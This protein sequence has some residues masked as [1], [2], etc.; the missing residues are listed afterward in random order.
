MVSQLINKHGNPA[1]NQ[2]IIIRK[3]ATYFQ[4]YNS[5]VCKWDGINLVLSLDWDYSNTTMKH[6]YIFLEQMGFF[7][8]KSAKDI[9]K[10]IKEKKI[11]LLEVSSL[12]VR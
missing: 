1:R 12:E 11:I 3:D 2:F 6:L 9:R 7:G 4:S 8:Y 10:A 5:V